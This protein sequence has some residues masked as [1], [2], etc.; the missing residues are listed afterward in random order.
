M[1]QLARYE[2][3]IDEVMREKLMARAR[4]IRPVKTNPASYT[5]AELDLP[6]TGEFHD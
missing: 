6:L 2:K 5:K 1:S 3:R 4:Q